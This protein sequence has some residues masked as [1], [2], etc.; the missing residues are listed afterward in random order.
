MAWYHYFIH[1]QLEILEVE[2]ISKFIQQECSKRGILGL[3]PS[4]TDK[5]IHRDNVP[6]SGRCAFHKNVAAGGCPL[7]FLRLF[8][9]VT[10]VNNFHKLRQY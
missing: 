10:E 7:F 2:F 1:V 8:I 6:W 9:I 4:S 3:F 5:H